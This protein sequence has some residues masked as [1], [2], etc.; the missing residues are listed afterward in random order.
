MVKRR[1]PPQWHLIFTGAGLFAAVAVAVF[2]SH[3]P[4]PPEADWPTALHNLRPAADIQIDAGSFADA[5]TSRLDSVL[6]ELGI[7]HSWIEHRHPDRGSID[8]I[9]VRVPVDLPIASVNQLLTD[10]IDWQ[11][12]HIVRGEE[13][14]GPSAVDLTCAIDSTITTVFRLRR[15]AQLR[16]NTGRIAIIVDVSGAPALRVQR[17]VR[18]A[19]PVTLAA[20]GDSMAVAP[21]AAIGEHQLINDIPETTQSLDAQSVTAADVGRRL[22]ALA[23][24][25]ANDG[26]ATAVAQLRPATLNALEEILPRLERRGYHFVTL[27]GLDN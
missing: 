10:F 6:A 27:T 5:V 16:R 13:R 18:L 23:E 20:R 2:V 26:Q 15:D 17:L 21:G 11:G 24:R 7:A 9:S 22:W 12:G 19:Q 25:S 4:P 14:R 1:R 3:L 8:T